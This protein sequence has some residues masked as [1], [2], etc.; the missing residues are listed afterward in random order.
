[1]G[2]VIRP[3]SDDDMG[4]LPGFGDALHRTVM[5]DRAEYL[6]AFCRHGSPVGAEVAGGVLSSSQR[7]CMQW[8]RATWIP[9]HGEKRGTPSCPE[10]RQTPGQIGGEVAWTDQWDETSLRPTIPARIKPMQTRRMG[11]ADSPNART[12]KT[13]V[14]TAPMPVQTVYAV[15]SGSD[16]KATPSR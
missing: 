12:P 1:M 4:V 6:D 9:A 5:S 13:T 7:S 15:P 14:P 11:S 10:T 16:F 8:G 2:L 3:L